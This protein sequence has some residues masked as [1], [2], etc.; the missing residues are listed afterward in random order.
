MRS[1]RSGWPG[2]V[3]WPRLDSWVYNSVVIGVSWAF[4][5][6]F[7]WALLWAFLPPQGYARRR[8]TAR[9]GG[10]FLKTD[11]G[12][13]LFLEMPFS[14]A[15]CGKDR[16]ARIAYG[17]GVGKYQFINRALAG[18]A[19]ALLGVVLAAFASPQRRSRPPSS[20]WATAT[21]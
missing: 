17:D 12:R 3:W 7:P 10:L 1:G 6:P 11:A 2:G 20:P 14:R 5:R 13:R 19:G 8:L 4:S 18:G 15:Q 16:L 21:P 9:T